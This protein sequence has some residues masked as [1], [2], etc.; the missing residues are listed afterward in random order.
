MNKL[1]ALLALT[2]ALTCAARDLPTEIKL[3][4]GFVMHDCTIVRWDP[5][6]ITVKYAGGTVPVR[7]ENIDPDQREA[8]EF[9][10]EAALKQQR[11]GDQKA[12]KALAEAEHKQ[13]LQ[14]KRGE[15]KQ[16][17]IDRKNAAIQEGLEQRRLVVGMT[18]DQ[19]RSMFGPPLRSSSL[20]NV[21]ASEWWIY[22]GLG[23]D[24]N[25]VPTNLQVHFKAGLVTRWNNTQR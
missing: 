25:G 23:K 14:E 18:M 16:T 9:H 6:V 12:A 21:A 5:D 7:F 8:I 22:P 15:R 20:T 4:N 10:R 24:G 19:V 11:I 1:F 17:E 3:T 13:N 2:V